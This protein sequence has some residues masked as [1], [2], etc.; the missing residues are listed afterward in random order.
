M[1]QKELFLDGKDAWFNQNIRSVRGNDITSD[2]I[3]AAP[4]PH[5]FNF[6]VFGVEL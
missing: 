5:T 2:P 6:E 4:I 1:S 3:F